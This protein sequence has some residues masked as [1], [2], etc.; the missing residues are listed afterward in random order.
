[1]IRIYGI[2]RGHICI[3]W[4][5]ISNCICGSLCFVRPSPYCIPVFSRLP[6]LIGLAVSWYPR[7]FTKSDLNNIHYLGWVSIPFNKRVLENWIK[8]N[9]LLILNT[10]KLRKNRRHFADDI[11]KCIFFSENVWIPIQISLKFVP[12]DPINNI[13]S[14]GSDNALA[15]TRRQAIIW[16]NDG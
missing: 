11:F 1:M 15:P 16:T 9:Q 5:N 12:K 7:Q 3:S 10:L 13:Y 14:T 6:E 4:I 2:N 8:L